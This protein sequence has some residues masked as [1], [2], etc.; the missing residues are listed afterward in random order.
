MKLPV[1][2][3]E[4][5]KRIEGFTPLETTRPKSPL[6]AQARARS[7]TGFTI[8]E[9][10]VVVAITVM[11]MSVFIGYSRSSNDQLVLFQNQA[12]VV[13]ALN[14]AKS[15]AVQRLNVPEACAFG[16]YFSG[17]APGLPENEFILFQ[18]NTSDGNC[19]SSNKALGQYES[20]EEIEK[21]TLDEGLRFSGPW[22]EEG[23]SII[24]IPPELTISSSHA[25]LPVSITITG[26]GKSNTIT[27][28]ASGQIT[29]Q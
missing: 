1:F 28:S 19:Q 21:I 14:K 16:V 26:R 6:G 23:E 29:G 7:L 9:S 24:F 27:V 22:S 3:R 17:L 20:G 2:L 18:D 12:R 10:L 11:L 13:G 5:S 8:I 4:I 25:E 15:L